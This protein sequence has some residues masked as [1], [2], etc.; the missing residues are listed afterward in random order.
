MF[1]INTKNKFITSNIQ[2]KDNY[3]NVKHQPPA[4]QIRK[5]R[6]MLITLE[7]NITHIKVY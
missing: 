4:H 6:Y 7:K 2:T 3:S 5:C 1:K